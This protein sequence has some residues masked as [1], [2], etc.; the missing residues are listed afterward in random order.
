MTPA[1]RLSEPRL[2][3]GTAQIAEQPTDAQTLTVGLPR[4][5]PES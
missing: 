3:A 2:A 1:Q 5:Q 4:K